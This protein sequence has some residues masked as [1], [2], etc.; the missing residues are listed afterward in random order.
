MTANPGGMRLVA[1]RSFGL[2]KRQPCISSRLSKANRISDELHHVMP[3]MAKW[4]FILFIA[5]LAVA[6]NAAVLDA[7]GYVPLI[8]GLVAVNSFAIALGFIWVAAYF[9]RFRHMG[10]GVLGHALVF[11]AA[12]VGFIGMGHQGLATESC[13]FPSSAVSTWASNQGAC[14]P[15]SLLAILIGIFIIWPS[16]KLLY[17]NVNSLL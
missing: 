1:C 14:T 17:G 9:H 5:L 4:F 13:V 8:Y 12:G 2:C 6:M 11:F 15:L 10:S 16:F 3:I 7:R